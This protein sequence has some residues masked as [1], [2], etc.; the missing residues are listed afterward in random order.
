MPGGDAVDHGAEKRGAVRGARARAR[1]MPHP[2]ASIAGRDG[3]FLLVLVLVFDRVSVRVPQRA[4]RLAGGVGHGDDAVLRESAE[5]AGV[6]RIGAGARRVERLRRVAL[7]VGFADAQ[8]VQRPEE[9]ERGSPR[10]AHHPLQG[11]IPAK[12][13]LERGVR[14]WRAVG[15]DD[16]RVDDVF[17]RFS[18]S[19]VSVEERRVFEPVFSF[20]HPGGIDE[21]DRASQRHLD[22]DRAL[23]REAPRSAR[24]R[25]RDARQ[26]QP[27]GGERRA[28]V[29]TAEVDGARA[30][31]KVAE[32]SGEVR[33]VAVH[34][35]RAQS[36]VVGG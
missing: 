19:G 28:K 17:R 22:R 35:R 29:R 7:G 20:V 5:K 27:R 1:E 31:Q 34:E 4:L 26:P 12:R 30:S 33:P 15:D 24:A 32:P 23:E 25:A 11:S 16:V 18:F 13:A 6:E 36:G 8:P 10:V 3:G 21:D 9:R 2:P 14:A